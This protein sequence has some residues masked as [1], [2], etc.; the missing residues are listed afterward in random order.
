MYWVNLITLTFIVFSPMVIPQGNEIFSITQLHEIIL[1]F[2]AFIILIIFLIM[3][4]RLKITTSE[5]LKLQSQVNRMNK[6]LRQS[7]SYIGETNRKLDIL[8][9]IA[10]AFP[11]NSQL[12]K[13][14]Q[15]DIYD[16]IMGAIQ[17]FGK[18]DEFVLRFVQ[19]TNCEVI[20]EIKSFP[21][22]K[23]NHPCNACLE[24]KFYDENEN[25]IAVTSPKTIDNVF[26]C[27]VIKKNQATKQIEDPEM[28]KTLA[29]QALFLFM[30]MRKER[31]E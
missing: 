17:I 7:Y 10:V 15:T 25:Y 2:L 3:E 13:I 24:N 4:R 8:E 16:S 14:K 1:S 19:K 31:Q 22:L 21:E 23:M 30:F 26:A 12:E 6:D 9:N 20:K 11:E 29:A 5:K 28:M 27:I 18:A